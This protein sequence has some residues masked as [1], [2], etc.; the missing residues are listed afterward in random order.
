M[1][2][3]PNHLRYLLNALYYSGYETI[4]RVFVWESIRTCC[5][6]KLF[7]STGCIILAGLQF[8]SQTIH[9]TINLLFPCRK[10]YFSFV[11][12]CYSFEKQI[13]NF[14]RK[15]R[16]TS[17]TAKSQYQIKVAKTVLLISIT[18]SMCYTPLIIVWMVSGYL[19]LFDMDNI[20][21]AQ[22]SNLWSNVLAYLNCCIGPSIYIVSS[23]LLRLW[24]EL[25]TKK[26]LA[27]KIFDLELK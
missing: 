27:N 5:I 19:Y 14:L 3:G 23:G 2:F 12:R 18:T 17:V 6:S 16:S 22:T 1:E 13:D 24:K 21:I 9:F 15:T 25:S 7:T 8:L 4:E 10:F 20:I 26:G 11:D